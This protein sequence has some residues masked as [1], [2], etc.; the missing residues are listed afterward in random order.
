MKKT[1]LSGAEGKRDTL[2]MRFPREA[3]VL[4]VVFQKN[5][6]ICHRIEIFGAACYTVAI[7]IRLVCRSLPG[8]AIEKGGEKNEGASHQWKSS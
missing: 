4:K 5:A 7:R 8:R 6:A 2:Q 3:P 1:H